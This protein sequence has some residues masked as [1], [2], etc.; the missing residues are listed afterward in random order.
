MPI[1]NL[2]SA[3]LSE[4]SKAAILKDL[5]SIRKRLDFLTSLKTDDVKGLFKAGT[6]YAPLLEKAYLTVAE[7]PEM[8]SN[9]FSIE[10]FKKDYELYKAL[11]PIQS[12][13][14][15]LAESI[16]RTMIALSSDTLLETLEIYQ[17]VKLNQN[18]LPGL[19]NVAEDMGAFFSRSRRKAA[20]A[21]K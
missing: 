3:T 14:E 19:T 6:A 16:G 13:V 11:A 21:A 12:Q 18:R 7:H 5:D 8:M 4:E 9:L 1:Q 17:T 2:V 15:Q 10:E 20:A